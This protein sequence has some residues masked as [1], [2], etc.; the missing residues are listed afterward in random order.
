[1]KKT[2][3]LLLL[4]LTLTFALP[5]PVLASELDAVT[6]AADLLTK[7][8]REELNDRAEEL[9]QQYQCAVYI[10]TLEE[11]GDVG[12]FDAYDLATAIYTKHNFGYGEE[13]SGL[14]FFLSMAERDYALISYGYGNT[15]F[16]DYGKDVLLDQNVLPLLGEDAYYEG[17]TAYLDTAENYLSMARDGKPFDMENALAYEDEKSSPETADTRF[18]TERSSE[19]EVHP[20]YNEEEYKSR[21][22]VVILLPLI[23]ATAL[24][25][26]WKGEMKTAVTARTATRYI[27]S[28]GFQLTE[29]KDTFLR[30]TETRRRIENNSTGGYSGGGNSGGSRSGGTNTR[31][32]GT[33]TR[34]GGTSTRSGGTN[35]RS[36]GT[37]TRSGGTNTRSGGFSGRS[38]KF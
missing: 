20:R 23:L 14:M 7:T 24:C 28:D 33:S 21:V 19:G 36:S 27:P 32:G 1:M 34:S 12:D 9:A 10:I 37:N 16:T 13:K 3:I 8:E 30:R 26:H 29:Q 38:G 11:M 18:E 2:G 15:A 31:S 25:I 17:F 4:M 5:L 6:D 22:T 35:T